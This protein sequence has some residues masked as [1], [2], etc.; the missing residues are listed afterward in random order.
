MYYISAFPQQDPQYT[1]YMYNLAVINPAYAGS[2]DEISLVSLYRNQWTGFNGAPKTIT[3]SGNAPITD[4]IGLG[5]SFISDQHG[6]VEE[7]NF[8]ADFS[9]TITTG[10]QS[11]L[12][13]GLKAGLTLHNI[14]LNS[15]VFTIESGDPLFQKD[16]AKFNP[17][18]GFGAFFYSNN[19]YLSLSIPNVLSSSY[20]DING[21]YYG[22]DV[23][24]FFFTSGYVFKLS[25]SIKCKPSFLIKTS[26]ND[27]ISFDINTNF[28]F[29]DKLEL[30]VSYRN[31]DSF[32]ALLGIAI[33]K[34]IKIGYAY[35][36]IL[37]DLKYAATGSHEIIINFIFNTKYKVSRS[38]R[39]F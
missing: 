8:Y 2:K 23:Q 29:Y 35:D 11:K 26:F 24:H 21:R 17:N 14:A 19:Y 12:A 33:T 5:V 3:F 39:F 37:S 1:Q 18:I 10:L 9:Y 15:D 22:R 4:K 36:Y 27:P 31:V 7:N 13:F 28:L 6:P 38:P 32:S 34:N 16:I 30:G 25:E 20:L